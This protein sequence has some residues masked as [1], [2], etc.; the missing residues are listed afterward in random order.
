MHLND[1]MLDFV[2]IIAFNVLFFSV[3]LYALIAADGMVM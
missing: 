3:L 1:E 2:L